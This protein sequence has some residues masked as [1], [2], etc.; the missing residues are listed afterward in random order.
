MV[1]MTAGVRG[2]MAAAIVMG[3]GGIA[4]ALVTGV[5]GIRAP[6]LMTVIIG[7]SGS[8]APALS[9]FICSTVHPIPPCGADP[10]F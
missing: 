7:G 5:R 8:R 2:I 3:V 10:C 1:S 6:A 4:P 9:I